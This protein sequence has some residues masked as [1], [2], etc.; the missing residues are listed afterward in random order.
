LVAELPVR[1]GEV[2]RDR[3]AISAQE[4]AWTQQ[5]VRSA[6][7]GEAYTP[8]M[9][10]ILAPVDFTRATAL[11]VA[12]AGKLAG[13][14]RAHV[15]LLNVV[16]VLDY[17]DT[18]VD[19][20]GRAKL[21]EPLETAA[22][23]QLLTL[24]ADLI[25]RGVSAHSLRLTGNPAPEILAQVRKLDPLCIVMASHGHTALYDLVVGSTVSAV[26][27]R[28]TCPVVIVPA[29]KTYALKPTLA[30]VRGKIARALKAESPQCDLYVEPKP[31]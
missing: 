7:V 11:V 4:T 12:E 6:F 13:A 23:R 25:A 24:K 9:K 26:V 5:R 2:I 15:V 8:R 17:L 10:F 18:A 1:P 31:P 16:R 21:V 22:E 28:A 29:R 19:F 20:G 14:Y 30:A 27:K 3:G